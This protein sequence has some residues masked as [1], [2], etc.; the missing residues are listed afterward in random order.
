MLRS[1]PHVLEVGSTLIG[2][3]APIAWDPDRVAKA[4]REPF[5]AAHYR[6]GKVE[7]EAL[8]LE[9]VS[10]RVRYYGPDYD[11]SSS[12]DVNTDLFPKDE[13]GG[14]EHPPRGL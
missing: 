8:L 4:I 14:S 9:L 6:R 3:D 1:F 2:S 12:R 13:Y 11:R 7:P 10:P 5:A